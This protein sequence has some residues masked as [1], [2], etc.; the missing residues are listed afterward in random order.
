MEK[1]HINFWGTCSECNEKNGT[2]PAE[3][4]GGLKMIKAVCA[5]YKMVSFMPTGGINIDNVNDY[6][7]FDRIVACGGTW[8]VP[9]KALNEDNYD[10]ITRLCK[11]AKEHIKEVR[12]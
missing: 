10:K 9:K 1:F 4:A 3:A 5:P 7:S 6:L 11:E 2:L 12:G 8:I